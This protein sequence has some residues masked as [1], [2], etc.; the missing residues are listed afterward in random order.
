M[1]FFSSKPNIRSTKSEVIQKANNNN[2][3][4]SIDN[5]THVG[6]NYTS[7]HHI[8]SNNVGDDGKMQN[9]GGSGN[10]LLEDSSGF[11]Y[12]NCDADK[13]SEIHYSNKAYDPQY[14]MYMN[15]I[16]NQVRSTRNHT[17][18][19][20]IYSPRSQSINLFAPK[21]NRTSNISRNF[22]D[23]LSYISFYTNNKKKLNKTSILEPHDNFKTQAN[24]QIVEQ[25][26]DLLK[27]LVNQENREQYLSA[28][29]KD[30]KNKLILK[31]IDQAKR[32]DERAHVSQTECAS[33]NSIDN[34]Q[35]RMDMLHLKFMKLKNEYSQLNN[36]NVILK[37]QI[38]NI[39]DN[40]H[41]INSKSATVS[42][43]RGSIEEEPLRSNDSWHSSN[44][45]KNN[46]GN[47][48]KIGNVNN[49]QRIKQQQGERVTLNKTISIN[50]VQAPVIPSFQK[51][52][53][54]DCQVQTECNLMSP[55]ADKPD[56]TKVGGPHSN[57][58]VS[59]NHLNSTFLNDSYISKLRE[60]IR[61]EVTQ[62]ITNK[63][64]Q[65]YK[66]ELHMLRQTIE[67][68]KTKSSN[69]AEES[70]I[71]NLLKNTK[72]KLDEQVKETI[73]KYKNNLFDHLKELINEASQGGKSTGQMNCQGDEIAT[74]NVNIGVDNFSSLPFNDKINECIKLF[75]TIT[76][77]QISARKI[78]EK[79]RDNNS[80][81]ISALNDINTDINDIDNMIDNLH[82]N[83]SQD[84][85]S[86]D[87][88]SRPGELDLL[89][90]ATS[91]NDDLDLEEEA[92]PRTLGGALESGEE[93]ELK[94]EI[95]TSMDKAIKCS[96]RG[97]K[98]AYNIDDPMT[99]RNDGGIFNRKGISSTDGDLSH[100]N[101]FHVDSHPSDNKIDVMGNMTM[102][103]NPFL[104]ET[105]EGGEKPLIDV[106]SKN[107]NMVM[108]HS[109]GDV[110]GGNHTGVHFDIHSD[111]QF[112]FRVDQNVGGETNVHFIETPEGVYKTGHIVEGMEEENFNN[113][114]MLHREESSHNFATN[115]NNAY[116][117]PKG[118]FPKGEENE[119]IPTELADGK[120]KDSVDTEKEKKKSKWKNIFTSKKTKKKNLSDNFG[121][122]TE[123]WSKNENDEKNIKGNI[124]EETFYNSTN[125]SKANNTLPNK[126]QIEEG[127]IDVIMNGVNN[128]KQIEIHS[129]LHKFASISY[130]SSQ[131]FM[132]RSGDGNGEKDPE[133]ACNVN[134]GGE[135][136]K[137]HN[138]N[139]MINNVMAVNCTSKNYG[140]YNPHVSN[141]NHFVGKEKFNQ[142]ETTPYDSS[143]RRAQFNP[144]NHQN[145]E[146]VETN[147]AYS[148]SSGNN[149]HMYQSNNET[150]NG[151]NYNTNGDYSSNYSVYSY[152]PATYNK[153]GFPSRNEE[154]HE[155]KPMYKEEC[156]SVQ[157]MNNSEDM[158][159]KDNFLFIE[160]NNKAFAKP[161]GNYQNNENANFVNFYN[162]HVDG[163]NVNN[164]PNCTD[165]VNKQYDFFY[166]L[167]EPNGE[168]KQYTTWGNQ[169]SKT[170]CINSY[171][172][173]EQFGETTERS[174][175]NYYSKTA[176]IKRVNSSA[177]NT[178]KTFTSDLSQNGQVNLSTK[179]EVHYN[180]FQAQKNKTKKNLEDLF[181]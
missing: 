93:G 9:D 177:I 40:Y 70:S 179:S 107:A 35:K 45:G 109:E 124:N 53:L 6:G 111:V 154:R 133:S 10:F 61:N 167:N 119:A 140:D 46:S 52:K 31:L 38:R 37:K 105:V 58:K 89:G 180:S 137:H 108:H 162:D 97:E 163:N 147:N 14:S 76:Q 121:D 127:E 47:T 139:G 104:E 157:I 82:A 99:V 57:L 62:E 172:W 132:N 85:F 68:Y 114:K 86:D 71:D 29:E 166:N 12:S 84:H 67:N 3:S 101:N 146:N 41:M 120:N 148:M 161:G 63:V 56:D 44:V 174:P 175:P 54:V 2:D 155:D 125:G 100:R 156:N 181:A 150:A 87:A 123:L 160:N 60:Q 151:P 118:D 134:K 153:T 83:I 39:K 135:E 16:A 11:A 1:N 43:P 28:Q 23:R 145:D 165:K 169:N 49:E 94:E 129:D 79:R 98:N 26:L 42:F 5:G 32:N 30:K 170:A 51:K 80:S 81:I 106:R 59:G 75:E 152:N 173:E 126:V 91:F 74:E 19:H 128:A 73:N 142:S 69:V 112:E 138:A 176:N 131:P 8:G 159:R 48:D 102:E 103:I 50:N 88:E 95:T 149:Q 13:M 130:Q 78:K 33:N 25:S 24:S 136:F 141:D 77:K 92:S 115:D 17:S 90:K 22:D 117:N 144:F 110:P 21:V 72:H 27:H 178:T 7:S 164:G 34:Y 20:R 96:Q 168:R 65:K 158:Y 171:K 122:D 66:E 64:E 4:C 18:S 36:E 15:K 116:D 55:I 113:E 143:N